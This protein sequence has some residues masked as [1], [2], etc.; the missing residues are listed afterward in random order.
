M[1]EFL[2]A[3]IYACWTI[4][5]ESAPYLLLGFLI[6]GLIKALVPDDK[7]LKHLGGNDLR[8]VVIA[9]AIG[10]PMP[11]CSCSV[12]PT[13][14]QLRKGGASKGATTAFLISTPETGVDQ[15]AVTWSLIDPMMAFLRPIAGVVTATTAGV[16][17]NLFV[18]LGWDVRNGQDTLQDPNS[19]LPEADACCATTSVAPAQA[20]D[21]GH[22]HGVAAG[23]AHDHDH[24]HDHAHDHP[25]APNALG[26]KPRRPRTVVGVLRE[27]T[28]YALG[29]MLDDLSRWFILGFLVSGLITVLVPPNYFGEVIP[30][31]FVA[32]LLML[33]VATPMYVCAT[34]STPVAAALIAKGLNPGAALVLL[35]A[36][37]ATSMATIFVVRR[38]LGL[39]STVVYVITIAVFALGFGLLADN[40]YAWFDRDPRALV[41]DFSSAPSPIAQAFAVLLSA[42]LLLSARRTRFVAWI[43]DALKS[44]SAPFG[45]DPTGPRRQDGRRP[46]TA[47]RLAVDGLLGGESGR[48]RL[49]AAFRQSRGHPHRARRRPAPALP[50]QQ[51]RDRP[52]RRS[53]QRGVRCGI[54]ELRREL[55]PLRRRR[56]PEQEQRGRARH[57]RGEPAAHLVR[58][59]LPRPR[60]ADLG[61]R[62]GGAGAPVA[63]L[64]RVVVAPLHRPYALRREPHRESRSHGGR[65]PRD[66]GARPRRHAYRHRSRRRPHPRAACAK[67]RPLPVPRCRVGARV[68]HVSRDARPRLRHRAPRARA[69]RVRVDRDRSARE[70]GASA[71]QGARR[72]QRVREHQ[73]GVPESCAADETPTRTR[74]ARSR[75]E[76]VHAGGPSRRS[77]D[78]GSVEGPPRLERV[79]HRRVERAAPA[80]TPAGGTKTDVERIPPVA[81][82]RRGRVARLGL[83]RPSERRRGRRRH[84]LR[85]SAPHARRSRPLLHVAGATRHRRTHRSPRADPRSGLG[86]VPDEGQEERHRRSVHGVEGH[87]PHALHEDGRLDGRRGAAPHRRAAVDHG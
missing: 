78:R 25:H 79:A 17:I 69:R 3:W 27:A 4:L 28:Q 41:E 38:L 51:G 64:R 61:V 84:A 80:G 53:P 66:P 77:R 9:S 42:L 63:R 24:A 85:R 58:R 21:H 50:V 43:G 62:I 67:R 75:A 46:R 15:L 7:I 26:A 22:D 81:A 60:S 18:K 13:A 8:S 56:G 48:D 12:L 57:R 45:F 2:S 86:R 83:L 68:P 72:R 52:H 39:R 31:G 71:R 76:E 34:G 73:R 29:P 35:L 44:A 33:V 30:N 74:S 59:A 23:H 49:R 19:A 54:D 10:A 55:R 65:D 14:A 87:R 16:I 20:H 6:A 37:P 47:W 36:G 82:V 40:L 1:I 5:C 32:M 11:L 70:G